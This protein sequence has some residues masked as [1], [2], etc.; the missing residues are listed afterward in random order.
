MGSLLKALSARNRAVFMEIQHN[1]S[2][3]R[4]QACVFLG[5]AALFFGSVA[6]A[7]IS[8]GPLARAHQSLNGDTNCTKC[9]LVSTKAPTFR[10]VRSEEHTSE[11]QSL[12]HL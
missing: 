1:W 7:Q 9:H 4:M 11:L 10:C 5:A 3:F 6:S 12:R 8:P 2:A